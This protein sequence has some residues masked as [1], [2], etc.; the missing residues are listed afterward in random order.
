MGA[1]AETL[2]GADGKF[3]GP[4]DASDQGLAES[5]ADSIGLEEHAL[6][7]VGT[8]RVDGQFEGPAAVASDE[9][10]E[11]CVLL[12]LGL[13]AALVLGLLTILVGDQASKKVKDINK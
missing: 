8:L 13:L 4:V 11:D 2:S 5:N 6:L 10:P 1:P 12:K 7:K 3:E 9:G